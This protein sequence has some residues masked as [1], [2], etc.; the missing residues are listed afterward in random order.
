V[1][2]AH[3]DGRAAGIRRSASLRCSQSEP[4]CR[5]GALF[6]LCLRDKRV[7]EQCSGN[8]PVPGGPEAKVDGRFHESRQR[9]T[10]LG[11]LAGIL[12]DVWILSGV[13]ASGVS[14]SVIAAVIHLLLRFCAIPRGLNLYFWKEKTVTNPICASPWIFER[15]RSRPQCDCCEFTS[16]SPSPFLEHVR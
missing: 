11:F 2:H 15:E 3:E 10:R 13:I 6:T 8:T 9:R 7:L 14:F 16:I 4:R 5:A 1:R 12:S